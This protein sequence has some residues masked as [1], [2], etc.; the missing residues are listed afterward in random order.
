MTRLFMICAWFLAG[1]HFARHAAAQSA[2]GAIGG[3]VESAAGKSL[4]AIVVIRPAGGG[5]IRLG[6]TDLN[7]NFAFTQ[8][9]PGKYTFCARIPAE[10]FPKPNQPY[11]DT[12]MWEQSQSPV[13]V[14][15]G[16][17]I[18]GVRV[19]VPQATLLQVQVNDPQGLLQ[20]ATPAQLSQAPDTQ[21][22]V[23]VRGTYGAPYRVPLASQTSAGRT[24]ALAVP[25]DTAMAL[26]VKSSQM[27]VL[28]QAGESVSS[29]I[30]LPAAGSAQLGPYQFTVQH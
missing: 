9:A 25:T 3:Q 12:C 17:T 5:A 6:Y 16:E 20:Q 22:E 4:R 14:S 7:G 21:L 23:L 13:A 28:N 10:Q 8:L 29:D 26:T 18:S 15:P 1:A 30:G 24:Y 27:T 2:T 19:A 11:L